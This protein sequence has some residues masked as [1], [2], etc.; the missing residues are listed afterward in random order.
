MDSK[1]TSKVVIQNISRNII[2]SILNLVISILVGLVFPVFVVQVIENENYG[3]WVLWQSWLTI[4][5]VSLFG[6]NTSILSILANLTEKHRTYWISFKSYFIICSSLGLIVTIITCLICGLNQANNIQFWFIPVLFLSFFLRIL[7]ELLILPSKT[8]QRYDNYYI[9][10][11]LYQLSFLLLSI[12]LVVVNQSVVSLIISSLLS[13]SLQFLLCL[14][15]FRKSLNKMSSSL[16][17]FVFN[18]P[19]S[20]TSLKELRNLGKLDI[21]NIVYSL[22]TNFGIKQI[23][24]VISDLK[25]LSYYDL[26]TRVTSQLYGLI[27]IA[28]SNI[29]PSMTYLKYHSPHL[30]KSF[31]NKGHRYLTIMIIILLTFLI[32]NSS[33]ISLILLKK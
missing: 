5:Q 20:F 27:A 25:G 19:F 23:I 18:T 21:I 8:L 7:G 32:A 1:D 24:P 15:Y 22:I 4:I 2:A 11:N 3:L 29:I 16:N 26:A 30:L 33:S 13:A 9:Q 12:A 31:I 28:F 14:V 6:I 17:V 10:K